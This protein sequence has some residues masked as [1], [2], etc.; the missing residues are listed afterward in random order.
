M[1]AIH[2]RALIGEQRHPYLWSDEHV[3]CS[4]QL[5]GREAGNGH[6]ERPRAHRMHPLA[7]EWLVQ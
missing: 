4:L 7:P 1:G 5:V 6:R 3:D 2:E